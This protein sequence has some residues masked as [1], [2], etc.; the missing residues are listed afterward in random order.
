MLPTAIQAM[1]QEPV[2]GAQCSGHSGDRRIAEVQ[3]YD[4]P[5]LDPRVVQHTRCQRIGLTIR[6][7]RIRPGKPTSQDEQNQ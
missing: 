1:N 5:A 4:Q 7:Q 2:A 3:V 6:S